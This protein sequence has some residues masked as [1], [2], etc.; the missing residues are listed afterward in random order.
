LAQLTGVLDGLTH[1]TLA[2]NQFDEVIFANQSARSLFGFELDDESPQPLAKLVPAVLVDLM[3]ET[4]KRKSPAPRQ[5]ELEWTDATGRT[6]WFRTQCRM[7]RD[8]AD[9]NEEDQGA[10]AVLT[11]IS[12]QR[13]IQKRHAEFVSAASHEMKTPLAGIRA[14]AEL[15]LDGED[16]DQETR[17]EFL[18]VIDT[19]ADRL[20]R[21]IENLLNIARIEAGVVKVEKQNSRSMNC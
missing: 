6:L 20:Q 18:G 13:N 10:V 7:M 8:S 19:Q 17:D 5:G 12:D 16:D 1:P 3:S 2:I 14:Y 11:D 15:L 21:L 4:C 9:Q